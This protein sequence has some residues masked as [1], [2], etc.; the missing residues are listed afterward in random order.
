MF[1]LFYSFKFFYFY[2]SSKLILHSTY[3]KNMDVTP[4]HGTAVFT[5]QTKH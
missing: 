2:F 1:F 3:G 4:G 5:V